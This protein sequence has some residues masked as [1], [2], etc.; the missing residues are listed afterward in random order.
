MHIATRWTLRESRLAIRPTKFLADRR[1]STRAPKQV[2]LVV[3]SAA[4]LG[5]EADAAS[6]AEVYRRAKQMGLELCPAEVGPQ[7]RPVPQSA[8]RRSARYRN[9]AGLDLCRRA[10]N[11]GPGELRDRSRAHRRRW[12]IGFHGAARASLRVCPSGARALGG[13]AVSDRDRPEL[14]GASQTDASRSQGTGCAPAIGCLSLFAG[15]LF[16]PWHPAPR[17]ASAVD[18]E[19]PRCTEGGH[20]C[21]RD[22]CSFS[23]SRCLASQSPAGTE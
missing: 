5:V 16:S 12:A 7:L 22:A 3:L 14:N 23:P 8:T 11:L 13:R 20:P 6:H 17:G 15:L 4:E 1:S 2:E 21:R 19:R 10:H 18:R 9:G